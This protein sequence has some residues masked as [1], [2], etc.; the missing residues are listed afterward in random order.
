MAVESS[1]DLEAGASQQHASEDVGL[2][3]PGVKEGE[4]SRAGPEHWSS[5][6]Q[7]DSMD[8]KFSGHVHRLSI[9]AAEYALIVFGLACSV[10]AAPLVCITLYLAAPSVWWFGVYLFSSVAT[11]L[12]TLG[13]KFLVGRQRPEMKEFENRRDRRFNIRWTENTPSMPSGDSSQAGCLVVWASYAFADNIA[14]GHVP[15]ILFL[16]GLLA[17]AKLVMFARVF[18]GLHWI[19]DTIVGVATGAVVSVSCINILQA[20]HGRE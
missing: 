5:L 18:Y 19:G 9:G 16:A 13:G 11:A 12:V 8:R 4:N 3:R 10:Y 6:S 7:L 1:L 20:I 14:Q 2:L 15:S 17:F